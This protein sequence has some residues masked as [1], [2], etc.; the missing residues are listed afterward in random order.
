MKT[1]AVIG[2]GQLGIAVAEY[3]TANGAEVIAIDRKM[4]SVE[5]VKDLV[6]RAL[7]LD[8][9]SEKALREAGVVECQC[10]VLALGEGQLEE[11]V[12]TTMLLRQLGVGRIISRAATDVQ[13]RVLETLGVS[14]VVFPER[15]IGVQIA[16]QLLTPSVHELVPLTEGTSMAEVSIPDKLWGKSLSEIQL[17][18]KYGV[19]AVGIK[20]PVEIAADDGAIELHWEIDN[21]PG[22]DSRLGKGDILVIVGP[23][24]GITQFMEESP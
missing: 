12:L 20:T 22:P 19:N 11:A 2:L 6:A 9:T 23:D 21:M 5:R 7:C 8:A 13:G 1:F 15:Q 16:R 24:D 18:R 4:E 17:R 3:L 10:V 14:K